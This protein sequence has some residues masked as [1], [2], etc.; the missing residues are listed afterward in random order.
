LGAKFNQREL[1]TENIEYAFFVSKFSRGAIENA[2]LIN[3]LIESKRMEHELNI[4]RDIQLS[5]LPQSVPKL[6][7]F[8]LSVIYEPIYEVGGDY[9]DILKKRKNN[10]LPI[11]I[12]DVEGKGLSASLLAASSQ[13]IL[14]SLNELYMFEPGKFITKANSLICQ[15]TKGKRFITLFW[16]LVN[17]SK[18]SITYVNAGHV[19]PLLISKDNVRRLSK[20]GFLTGFT[21]EAQYEKETVTMKPGDLLVTFTDGV[22]EVENKEGEEFGEDKMIE[23]LQKNSHLPV[24]ELTAS[25]FQAIKDFSQNRKFRDDFTLILLKAK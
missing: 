22:T 2:V 1:N 8:D 24:D 10:E 12:A 7:N 16:M 13:A 18:Q 14:H 17:D 3:R 4:A 5:L 9:Y 15:F 23:F 11:L 20:G 21:E 6:K 25:L 19:E